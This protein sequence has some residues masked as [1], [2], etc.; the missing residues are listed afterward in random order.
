MDSGADPLASSQNAEGPANAPDG[1]TPTPMSA[2]DA[3]GR[4]FVTLDLFLDFPD[5]RPKSIAAK[6]GSIKWRQGY[7]PVSKK[8]ISTWDDFTEENI[9]RMFHDFLLEREYP[10][11]PAN[12]NYAYF[13]A[14]P[15]IRGQGDEGAYLLERE[16]QIATWFSSE[17]W[18]AICNSLGPSVEELQGR[19]NPCD[20]L[21]VEAGQKRRRILVKKG[22]RTRK[23]VPMWSVFYE[24]VPRG[25]A[26]QTEVPGEG[27]SRRPCILVTGDFKRHVN[28]DP[29]RLA[30]PARMTKGVYAV[31][32]KMLMYC[33]HAKTRYAFVASGDDITFLR[34]YLLRGGGK[35]R[36]GVH[37]AVFPWAKKEGR[38][39]ACKG[40][41]ALVM[42]S[43]NDQHRPIASEDQTRDLNDWARFEEKGQTIWA[44]HLSKIVVAD[45]EQASGFRIVDASRDA[46]AAQ[47]EQYSEGQSTGS[48]PL[49]SY[50]VVRNSAGRVIYR[51][52]PSETVPNALERRKQIA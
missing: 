52:P 21:E 41:W 37:Y 15:I 5:P 23:G 18:R 20:P 4:E 50:T 48:R 14:R 2:Y 19:V 10:I 30:D 45:S 32:G 42:L 16:I 49:T 44:N 51:S 36:Y 9:N 35:K 33:V 46:F 1:Y 34:F 47:L 26:K 39:L 12:L 43:L 31:L 25:S 8:H 27:S 24:T 3:D 22:R 6:G 17:V 11:Y 28:F 7:I 13:A 38:M 40:I 29:S